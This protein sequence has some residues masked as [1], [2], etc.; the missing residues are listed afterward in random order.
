MKIKRDIKKTYWGLLKYYHTEHPK[1]GKDIAVFRPE[2]TMSECCCAEEGYVL[3]ETK[4]EAQKYI[5]GQDW[6]KEKLVKFTVE[7]IN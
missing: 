7:I 4:K 5:Y 6:Q 1:K 2:M 3:Y